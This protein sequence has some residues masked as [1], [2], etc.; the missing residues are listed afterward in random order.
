M[1]NRLPIAAVIAAAVATPCTP[2]FAGDVITGN[3]LYEWC[4]TNDPA[5]AQV[6]Q[7][8]C[9]G[10]VAAIS[11]HVAISRTAPVKPGCV[12]EDMTTLQQV[13]DIVIKYLRA[14]PEQRGVLAAAPVTL[15]IAQAY[16]PE[17]A[18]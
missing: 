17:G 3:K 10:F 11:Q 18:K 8:L 15:A 16:C 4:T 5:T 6:S 14:H 13:I 2:A 9:L 7:A 12:P 1:K